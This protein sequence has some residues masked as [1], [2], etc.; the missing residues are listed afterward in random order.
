MAPKRKRVNNAKSKPAVEAAEGM[1]ISN[2]FLNKAD[3][4]SASH[5]SYL[6]RLPAELVDRICDFLPERDTL[7]HLRAACRDLLAKTSETYGKLYWKRIS[8]ILSPAGWKEFTKFASEHSHLTPHVTNLALVAPDSQATYN[9]YI[10][11]K[12]WGRSTILA[13]STTMLG[14]LHVLRL[15]DFD[16]KGSQVYLRDFC[17]T[18][19]LPVLAHLEVFDMVIDD[20]SLATLMEVH[21]KTL[22]HVILADVDVHGGWNEEAQWVENDSGSEDGEKYR[23][24]WMR[25]F[26]A[27]L[28]F[29]NQ[30]GVH[31]SKPRHMGKY[32]GLMDL[33]DMTLVEHINR[34]EPGYDFYGTTIRLVPQSTDGED[35]NE[36]MC[37]SISIKSDPEWKKGVDRLMDMYSYSV[38]DPD[39]DT[40]PPWYD[41]IDDAVEYTIKRLRKERKTRDNARR[42]FGAGLA[43]GDGAEASGGPRRLSRTKSSN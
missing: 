35:A 40:T 10:L 17:R 29:E 7:L 42:L 2:G 21:E 19:Y 24:P 8:W 28:L 18:V 13:D 30:C 16:F 20:V 1:R 39:G 36:P 34:G 9:N 15:L 6:D 31:I 25:V 41:E 37:L 22:H 23:T 4:R 38:N 43:G 26:E 14:N 3:A 32:V 5:R 11:A 12:G 33:D 27:M